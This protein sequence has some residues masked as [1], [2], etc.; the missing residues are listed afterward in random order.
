MPAF[1]FAG[2]YVSLVSGLEKKGGISWDYVTMLYYA[3][4]KQGKATV[5]RYTS[6]QIGEKICHVIQFVGIFSIEE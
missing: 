4:S 5:T 2:I 6:I 1:F 3:L